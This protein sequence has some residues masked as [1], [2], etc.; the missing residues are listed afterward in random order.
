MAIMSCAGA[1]YSRRLQL[2]CE[3]LQVAVLVLPRCIHGADDAFHLTGI[4]QPA[5]NCIDGPVIVSGQDLLMSKAG[6]MLQR[7]EPFGGVGVPIDDRNIFVEAL[8]RP[9][10][11]AIAFDKIIATALGGVV[12]GI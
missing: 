9:V 1:T 12:G 8:P 11:R 10:P 4:T 2:F 5:A 3:W 6:E 7:S